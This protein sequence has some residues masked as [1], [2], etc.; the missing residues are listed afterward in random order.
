LRDALDAILAGRKPARPTVP[1]V[2][3]FIAADR[4]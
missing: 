3:C 4:E 2:G 1:A